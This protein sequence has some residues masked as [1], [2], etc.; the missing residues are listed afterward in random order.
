MWMYHSARIPLFFATLHLN[1]PFLS[2]KLKT[3]DSTPKLLS[4]R[5]EFM[6]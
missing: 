2:L 4:G 1:E 6:S 5:H 3:E